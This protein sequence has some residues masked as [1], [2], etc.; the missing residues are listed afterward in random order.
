MANDLQEK[1]RKHEEEQIK[2]AILENKI[3]ELESELSLLKDNQGPI[4]KND[5]P[6]NN[7]IEPQ[8][9]TDAQKKVKSRRVASLKKQI[10]D[11]NC[12]ISELLSEKSQ[13]IKDKKFD[14]ILEKKYSSEI[15]GIRTEID[16]LNEMI[17]R[18]ENPHY[19]NQSSQVNKVNTTK[20]EN[21]PEEIK[22]A[23]SDEAAKQKQ[24]ATLF[25]AIIGLIFASL[26]ISFF[27]SGNKK[28]ATEKDQDTI[29][30]DEQ[31]SAWD[32][33]HIRLGKIAKSSLKFPDTYEHV[34]SVYF[35]NNEKRN[36]VVKTTFIGQ[37]AFG[38]KQRSCIMATYS[39]TGTEIKQP[40]SC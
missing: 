6:N 34:N 18:I 35:R 7:K 16:D 22:S 2:K 17:N 20:K 37:N 32:G 3:K 8:E 33:E 29:W 40:S 1:M 39:F 5:S 13:L 38:V 25:E 10:T 26:L 9:L 21:T 19:K 30:I 24:P 27:S 31:F 23:S 15:K 14:S 28:E 36:I 11:K 12:K 4:E